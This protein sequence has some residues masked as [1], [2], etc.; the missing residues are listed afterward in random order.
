MRTLGQEV[1]NVKI[2]VFSIELLAK[3]ASPQQLL[4]Q[5]SAA[6]SRLADFLSPGADVSAAYPFATVEELLRPFEEMRQPDGTYSSGM[7]HLCQMHRASAAPGAGFVL[8]E[9]GLPAFREALEHHKTPVFPDPPPPAK[10]RAQISANDAIDAAGRPSRL[11]V[12]VQGVPLD[13]NARHEAYQAVAERGMEPSEIISFSVEGVRCDLQVVVTG[14]S[15]RERQQH[16]GG[17]F[18]IYQNGQRMQTLGGVPVKDPLQ[19]NLM[20]ASAPPR[21]ARR[22]CR[23]A[24][25]LAA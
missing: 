13:F 11:Q 7:L 20:A 23:N 25:L 4:Q 12:V 18:C 6:G 15:L 5:A 19:D 3:Q 10:P 2:S 1:R 14:G 16:P 17:L 24:P 22:R 8:S 21:P 9:A